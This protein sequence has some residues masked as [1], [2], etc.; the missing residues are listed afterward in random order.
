M[1]SILEIYVPFTCVLIIYYTDAL[2][3][4]LILWYIK[5]I[6]IKQ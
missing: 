6:N 3:L 1:D 5:T 4:D 2:V